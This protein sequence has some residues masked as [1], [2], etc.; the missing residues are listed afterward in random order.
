MRPLNEDRH[1]LSSKQG[2]PVIIKDD[3]TGYQYAA[4][5]HKCGKAGLYLESNYAP[6][7]GSILNIFLENR[8]LGG[9]PYACP[10]VIKWRKLLC[11]PGLPWSYGLG[12]K[13]V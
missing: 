11:W 8:E 4:S 2:S 9:G 1:P 5:M 10:A 12:L 3:L 13:Y 6:R 7:P